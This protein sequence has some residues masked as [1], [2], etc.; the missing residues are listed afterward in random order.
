MPSADRLAV[1]GVSTRRYCGVRDHGRLLGE[2]L[3]A[4]GADVRDHWLDISPN[5][6][7]REGR[8]AVLDFAAELPGELAAER[9][10]GVVFHYSVFAYSHRGLPVNGAPVVR[11]LRRAGAPVVS[12]LHEVAYPWPT[13]ADARGLVWALSQRAAA[14][15][16]FAASRAVVV[17]ADFRA[18]WLDGA[19]WLPRRPVRVAPVFS[20]LPSSGA[21]AEPGAV[22][23]FGWA[24]D[25]ESIVLAV[26]AFAQVG[27]SDPS[28]RLHLLG[29]PGPDSEPAAAWRRAAERAGVADRLQ[30]SGALGAAELAERLAR[31]SVFLYVDPS[32]LTGRKGTLAAELAAG[33]ALLAAAGRR[34]WPALESSGGVRVVARE[35]SSLGAALGQL[36]ADAPQRASLAVAG[37]DF[38]AREMSVAHTAD[39]VLDLL[40][41]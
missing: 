8:R 2:E 3:R 40:D 4:R 9:C 1:V 7:L 5:A 26:D 33:R 41:A 14:R 27:A 34:D 15:G 19:R 21:E 32:G 38:Y 39:V 25:E 16:V 17:T 11:A 23:V 18:A 22:G 37:R 30:F 10:Q 13:H 12:V 20:N 35:P 29:A 6:S 31:C 24:F 28:A 36:L